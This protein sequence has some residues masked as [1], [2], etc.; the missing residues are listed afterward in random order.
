MTPLAAALDELAALLR[1]ARD[2][3]W[4]IGSA[5]AW[6]HG[7]ATSV[8]DVDVLLSPRDARDAMSA[9]RGDVVVGEAGQRFRSVPFARL[10]G[11]TLPIELMPGLQV[12]SA[13]RWVAVWP[14]TRQSVGDVYVPERAELEAIF[15]L[16]GRPKDRARADLLRGPAGRSSA[17]S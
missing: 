7:A 9:W 12:R 2:A 16:F 3:W 4:V 1:G 6:L 14:A 8:A 10:E 5:A 11:A 13:N 15:A 17:R